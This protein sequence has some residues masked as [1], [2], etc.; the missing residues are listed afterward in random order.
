MK[1]PTVSSDMYLLGDSVTAGELIRHSNQQSPQSRDTATFLEV[2]M[3]RW[4][5][6]WA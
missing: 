5:R 2:Y 1:P 4:V 3:A 6:A